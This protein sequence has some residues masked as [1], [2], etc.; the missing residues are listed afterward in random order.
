MPLYNQAFVH[1][2]GHLLAEN[3]TVTTRLDRRTSDIFSIT[4][5]F[6][7]QDV[8]PFV[9]VIE[10]GNV[11]PLAGL[12][13]DFERLMYEGRKVELMITDAHGQGHAEGGTLISNGTFTR[14]NRTAGVGQNY[15]VSFTF[16]GDA[17]I[18]E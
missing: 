2:D 3:T 10:A 16:R 15:R 1:V 14:V 8:G 13:Q 4:K 9:R 5:N 6:E 11:V 17:S 18:F 12:E 7:G